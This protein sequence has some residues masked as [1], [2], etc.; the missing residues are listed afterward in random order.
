MLGL[1]PGMRMFE[2]KAGDG[3]VA[4]KAQCWRS[5]YVVSDYEM[6]WPMVCGVSLIV[7]PDVFELMVNRW[8]GRLVWREFV[9]GSTELHGSLEGLT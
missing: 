6:S 3:N 2:M 1:E 8:A 7:R 9:E 5:Q 4:L